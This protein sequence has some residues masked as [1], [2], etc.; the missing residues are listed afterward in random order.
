MRRSSLA[1]IVSLL[2][3]VSTAAMSQSFMFRGRGPG[4]AYANEEG[5]LIA[6]IVPDSPAERA[7]LL[8]GDVLTSIEDN[9]VN[10]PAEV[11]EVLSDYKAGQR[12]FIE[13]TRGGET[14]RKSLTLEDR[15]YRPV[16]GLEFAGGPGRLFFEGDMAP[17]MNMFEGV[18]I[19]E[20]M[21]NSPAARAGLGEGDVILTIDG[22]EV[23]PWN[24]AETIQDYDPGDSVMVT[25][26]N[27]DGDPVEK[28]IT[29]G[30]GDDGQALLGVRYH[31]GPRG[32]RFSLP[33]G[34]WRERLED[35]VPRMQERFHERNP[36]P[37]PDNA[38]T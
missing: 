32:F 25:I 36:I 16:L 6:Q 2:L 19:E 12:I 1:L 34:E 21:D 29:L 23:H 5:L 26:A 7:G 24:I 30:E 14:M 8:R 38:D 31:L 37:A 35:V 33:E 22:E 28:R 11:R 10:T 18:H 17:F 13:L 4:P 20:V 27:Q 3:I 9:E 15:L